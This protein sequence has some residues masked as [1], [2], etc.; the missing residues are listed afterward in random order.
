MLMVDGSIIY[1]NNASSSMKYFEKL[2]MPVPPHSNPIDHYMK[3]MNKEGIA[4]QYIERGEEY[5]E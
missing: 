5:E 1:N 3:L 2:G 4:L